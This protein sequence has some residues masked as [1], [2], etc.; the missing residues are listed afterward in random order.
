MVLLT[1]PP[2][3]LVA[4][5]LELPVTLEVSDADAL[6]VTEAAD[7]LVTVTALVELI[8]TEPP[9]VFVLVT[10]VVLALLVEFDDVASDVSAPEESAS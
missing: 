8:V 9:T 10:M 1:E 6:V 4:L 3:P 2:A 5:E 7:V